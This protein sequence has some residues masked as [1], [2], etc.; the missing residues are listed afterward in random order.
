[1]I[2]RAA[3]RIAALSVACAGACADDAASTGGVEEG[4][5]VVH[6]GDLVDATGEGTFSLASTSL[7]HR[8]VE[9]HLDGEA[10]IVELDVGGS[11][12]IELASDDGAS[13]GPAA[14]PFDGGMWLRPRP[15]TSEV[16]T[17]TPGDA[18]TAVTIHARGAPV[19]ATRRERS[20]VWSDGALLD[21]PEIVG[22]RRVLEAAS[23]D[24]RGGVLLDAWFRRFATTLHSE[25]AAP[26]Q[27][28]DELASTLGSDPATWDLDAL[29]FEVTGVHNRLD[30]AARGG[31]CGELRV[32]LAS[33]HPT[34]APLHLLFLFR[35]EPREDDVGPDGV[36][37]CL[38]TARRWSRLSLLDGEDFV[39][40]ARAVLDE[41]L[42]HERFLLA[43]SVELTVSPWE[44]R[45]WKPSGPDE[46]DNPSLFQT[47]ATPALNAPGPLRDLFLAFVEA[48]ADGLLSRTV[49]IPAQFRGQ[50][51]RVPPS[52]PAERLSLDGLDPAVLGAR[53]GL[54]QAIEIVGCPTCHTTNASFVQT[55]VDRSFSDFYD[56]ELDAR[57]ARLDAMH[58]G[59]PVPVPPFGPL[60]VLP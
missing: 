20:L 26:A 23:D 39:G 27:L 7:D 52:A 54:A 19:P 48:N 44:W 25:R 16:L 60:Q 50:S 8:A 11:T 17:L 49:E 24:G 3:R 34:Y 30:L 12:G 59:D 46:L 33:T 32:S 31:G 28:M 40:A 45:Q 57:A 5:I 22:A 36:V 47:V 58:T 18:A 35:Q 37:H 15:I 55:N 1:M 53:P 51:A 2:S 10:R 13:I 4:P 21:A 14:V 6:L 9:I 38:G 43:E 29:P 56:A 41:A 42:V